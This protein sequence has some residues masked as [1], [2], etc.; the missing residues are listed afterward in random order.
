MTVADV[1]LPPLWETIKKF[2]QGAE[3]SPLPVLMWAHYLSQIQRVISG[4]G[5][6]C[7]GGFSRGAYFSWGSLLE[8]R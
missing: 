2:V 5:P 6:L 8:L 4:G 7:L 3:L 1:K